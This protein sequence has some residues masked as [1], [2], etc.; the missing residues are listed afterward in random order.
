MK[1]IFTSRLW[2]LLDL[3]PVVP[4]VPPLVPHGVAGL[5]EDPADCWLDEHDGVS[6]SEEGLETTGD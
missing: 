2:L 3:P 4:L 1:N 5:D 6:L